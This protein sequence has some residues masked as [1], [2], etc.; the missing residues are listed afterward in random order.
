MPINCDFAQDFITLAAENIVPEL[1]NWTVNSKLHR[2][3]L[4]K[5]CIPKMP[6]DL[7]FWLL[8][9]K[10]AIQSSSEFKYKMSR[11]FTHSVLKM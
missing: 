9:G 2:W 11:S 3:H 10:N 5:Y 8:P 4:G 6:E 1:T 7:K